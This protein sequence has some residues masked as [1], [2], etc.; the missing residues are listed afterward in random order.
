ML[1]CKAPTAEEMAAVREQ[2][3]R[4]Q[5]QLD[6]ELR[7]MKERRVSCVGF[8]VALQGGIAEANN[9]KSHYSMYQAQEHVNTRVSSA[10]HAAFTRSASRFIWTKFPKLDKYQHN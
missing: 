5:R 8:G 6:E 9:E 3:K 4:E 2:A 10:L 1:K 7:E